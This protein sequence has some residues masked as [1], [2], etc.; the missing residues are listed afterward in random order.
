[1]VLH[2][3]IFFALVAYKG[4]YFTMLL[5]SLAGVN[6][7]TMHVVPW[8]LVGFSTPP[9]DNGIAFAFVNVCNALPSVLLNGLINPGLSYIFSTLIPAMCFGGAT[10]LIAGLLSLILIKSP[11][12]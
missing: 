7:A 6:L 4:Q 11:T 9:A 8:A 3:L 10:M 1:M 2:G 5:I 12:P